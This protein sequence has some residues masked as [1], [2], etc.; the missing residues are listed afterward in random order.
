M[1]VF[2]FPLEISICFIGEF[3]FAN[4]IGL[5]PKQHNIKRF[6]L[7]MGTAIA[8]SIIT[9][10]VHWT[11]VW[12]AIHDLPIHRGYMEYD[13]SA[14]EEVLLY[15]DAEPIF[16]RGLDI[17]FLFLAAIIIIGVHFPAI[18]FI[19]NSNWKVAVGTMAL[20]TIFYP[21][22]WSILARQRTEGLYME[23]TGQIFN[24]TLLLALAFVVGILLIFI[25][26]LTLM[27]TGTKPESNQNQ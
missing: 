7:V 23:K 24:I 6:L 25:W 2:T 4:A 11:L 10:L 21:I 15:G 17:F 1:F 26:R 19:Q 20:P 22:I 9:S 16:S 3:V 18:R 8:I 14:G 27:G 12:P 13:P 5:D